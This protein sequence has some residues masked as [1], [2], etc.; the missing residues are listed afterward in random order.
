VQ[1]TASKSGSTAP[2]Q[3]F[4]L[5]AS[6]QTPAS[7]IH[8]SPNVGVKEGCRFP[9]SQVKPEPMK[10]DVVL[11]LDV[12]AADALGAQ[13]AVSTPVKSFHGPCAADA[14]IKLFIDDTCPFG[15]IHMSS[16]R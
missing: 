16:A 6:R 13:G 2:A 1:V 11:K 15:K 9:I 4:P 7:I 5:E 12:I 8:A 14:V 10:A 3:A